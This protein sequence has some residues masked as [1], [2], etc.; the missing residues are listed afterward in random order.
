MVSEVESY[1]ET[2]RRLRA[3]DREMAGMRRTL[4]GCDW[5]CGGGDERMA[6]LVRQY[7]ALSDQQYPE[8]SKLCVACEYYDAMG[9]SQLCAKCKQEDEG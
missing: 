8:A 6:D 2:D 4:E 7:N 3:I 1:F 5:C 9:A